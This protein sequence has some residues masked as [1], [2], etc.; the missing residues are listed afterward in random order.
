ML[1]GRKRLKCLYWYCSSV[2]FSHL[3]IVTYLKWNL[4]HSKKHDVYSGNAIGSYVIKCFLK[5]VAIFSLFCYPQTFLHATDFKLTLFSYKNLHWIKANFSHICCNT[6]TSK[7]SEMCSKKFA[8]FTTFPLPAGCLSST[9]R[10]SVWKF[11]CI[12]KN[13]HCWQWQ[14]K[15][16]TIKVTLDL[17]QSLVITIFET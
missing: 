8:Q 2:L 10:V 13:I 7:H 15:T 9:Y 14:S 6:N 17:N 16:D 5:V 11:I 12:R 1:L 4:L 3:I